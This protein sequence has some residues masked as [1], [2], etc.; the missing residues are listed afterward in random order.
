MLRC[1]HDFVV[2]HKELCLKEIERERERFRERDLD[3]YRFREI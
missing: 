3:I 1:I 2:N